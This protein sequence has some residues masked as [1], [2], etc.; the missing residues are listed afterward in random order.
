MNNEKKLEQD[1]QEALKFLDSDERKRYSNQRLD[2]SESE[3]YNLLFALKKGFEINNKTKKLRFTLEEVEK[4]YINLESTSSRIDFFIY[5]LND[6]LF[7]YF[8]K[9]FY[10][11]LKPFLITSL[12]VLENDENIFNVVE[13][14]IEQNFE[15]FIKKEDILKNYWYLS[16]EEQCRYE[17]LIFIK[18]K[19]Y[20]EE[21]E[22]N[23][24][25]WKIGFLNTEDNIRYNS[26]VE[27]I[28]FKVFDDRPIFV[29]KKIVKNIS[30]ILE[31]DWEE[32]S[33]VLVKILYVKWEVHK[34][35]KKEKW[36]TGFT[37]DNRVYLDVVGVESWELK[38]IDD[39]TDSLK[40]DLDKVVKD[41]V[42]I[43]EEDLKVLNR[44]IL[45][46]NTKSI[47]LGDLDDFEFHDYRY[48]I[49]KNVYDRLNK[50][51]VKEIPRGQVYIYSNLDIYQRVK[52]LYETNS[53]LYFD[54]LVQ[55]FY[56]FYIENEDLFIKRYN[57]S[58]EKSS[59]WILDLELVKSVR[60]DL[61]NY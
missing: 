41:V 4:G 50:W 26:F 16:E 35:L 43:L 34:L 22:L 59:S 31:L 39:I 60:P 58:K 1:Y 37:E 5:K 27:Q 38:S 15:F 14:I 7:D 24:L 19:T 23:E 47:N 61:F 53:V 55:D 32:R 13:N 12:S 52:I 20:D 33:T 9:Y 49:E 10:V 54:I 18:E 40:V 28:W 21:K 17:E 45:L 36:V 6:R 11:E 29:G 25:K 44:Q 3:W 8:G 57:K 42:L 30:E 2:D 46:W 51:S 48:E 56:D